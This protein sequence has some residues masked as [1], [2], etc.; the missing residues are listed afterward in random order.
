VKHQAT[1]VGPNRDPESSPAP[2]GK[3]VGEKPLW[4][5][6]YAAYKE[7]RHAFTTS[8]APRKRYGFRIKVLWIM[9]P[10]QEQ[11]VK[12]MGSNLDNGSSLV[13]AVE[14][15]T[16]ATK[17]TLDPTEG[18]SETAWGEFPSYVYFDRAGC[19][20]LQA[21]SDERSWRLVFGFG[22]R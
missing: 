10:K 8:D 3:L 17:A 20:E 11:P 5:G 4:A 15:G 1:V 21:I 14:G 19:F 22:Q 16:R 9:H 7:D 2:T 12:V 6:F 18:V 13:F